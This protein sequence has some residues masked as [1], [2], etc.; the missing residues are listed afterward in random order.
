MLKVFSEFNLESYPSFH[1]VFDIFNLES[2]STLESGSQMK[3]LQN[4]VWRLSKILLT[5]VTFQSRYS[6]H[7][8]IGNNKCTYS[9][10]IYMLFMMC[11]ILYKTVALLFLTMNKEKIKSP[12]KICLLLIFITISSSSINALNKK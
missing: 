10:Q 8:L 12:Y 11:T 1:K 2:T 3:P 6:I 7:H 4:C 5:I 9:H